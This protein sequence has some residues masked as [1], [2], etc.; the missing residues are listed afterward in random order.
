MDTPFLTVAQLAERWNCSPSIIYALVAAR[1]LGC[2]RI[3]LGRGC[4]RFTEEHVREYL[5]RGQEKT[6]RFRHLT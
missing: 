2:V 6:R 4:I 5:E 1:Q 3:G